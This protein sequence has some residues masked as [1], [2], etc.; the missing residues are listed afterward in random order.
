MR[1]P[2]GPRNTRAARPAILLDNIDVVLCLQFRFAEAEPVARRALQIDP[3]SHSSQYLVG[4]ILVQQK[5]YTGEATTLLAEAAAQ[6]PR[7]WLFLAKASLARGNNE[8]AVREFAAPLGG[9]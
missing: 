7:A 8:Q 3:R 1:L 9:G 4:G 5:Q 2:N 6:Y